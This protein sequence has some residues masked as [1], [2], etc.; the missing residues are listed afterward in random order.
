MGRFYF[1]YALKNSIKS[2][3]DPEVTNSTQLHLS[4]PCVEYLSKIFYECRS[5]KVPSKPLAI[6]NNDSM[7][8]VSRTSKEDI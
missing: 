4:P 3:G 7:V 1:S 5:G 8:D 2:K 6:M